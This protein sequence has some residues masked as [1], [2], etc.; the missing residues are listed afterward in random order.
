MVYLLH[1]T[2]CLCILRTIFTGMADDASGVF[3]LVDLTREIFRCF[4]CILDLDSLDELQ[5]HFGSIVHV[6]RVLKLLGLPLAMCVICRQFALLSEDE[7][8]LGPHHLRA[9]AF[10]PNF[11]GSPIRM[12][13]QAAGLQS[14]LQQSQMFFSAGYEGVYIEHIRLHAGLFTDHFRAVAEDILAEQYRGEGWTSPE[15]S[16]SSDEEG[17]F[18]TPP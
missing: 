7:H 17:Q 12:V 13:A 9:L 4:I 15:I 14:D 1:G 10:Y 3:D 18:L 16:D 11:V 6:M 8:V 5:E 2:F